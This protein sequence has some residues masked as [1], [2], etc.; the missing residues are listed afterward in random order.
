MADTVARTRPIAGELAA[1]PPPAEPRRRRRRWPWW[2]LGSIVVV[3]IGLQL[4]EGFPSW[5]VRAGQVFDDLENWALQNHETSP[6]F[7]YFFNPS[8]IQPLDQ[9]GFPITSLKEKKSGFLFS[10]G[11]TF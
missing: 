2:V 10:I 11:R 3:L 6:L 1:P 7:I 4:Q 5:R 8:T 9:F